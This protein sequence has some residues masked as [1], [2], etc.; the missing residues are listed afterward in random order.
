[1]RR[2]GLVAAGFGLY[3]AAL[4]TQAPATLVDHGLQQASN[5]R[6]RL[7]QASGTIWSGAGLIEIRDAGGRNTIARN[8]AWRILPESM[9]RARLACEVQLEGAARPFFVTASASKIEIR[10]L[11]LDLPAG[12]LALAEPSL[13]PLHLS[14]EV[15][16]QTSNLSIGRHGM[17]GNLTV[18]WR[19]AGSAFSPVSPLGSYELKLE[20]KGKTVGAL[21]AT[22]QGPVQLDG[23]GTWATGRKPDFL[24]TVRVA[25]ENREQLNPLLRL[26]SVQR[27]EGTFELQLK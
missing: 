17:L 9:W 24:A 11:E 1:M 15:L 6:L 2:R 13:M 23:S 20:G 7:T 4:I 26:I 22:L 19:S 25:P 12:A 5:G 3:A 10:G 27:D 16:L 18:Q 8:A 14:G 21:L